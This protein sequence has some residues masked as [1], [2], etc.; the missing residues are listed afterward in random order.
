M[1]NQHP[2]PS[3]DRVRAMN[4]EIGNMRRAFAADFAAGKVPVKDRFGRP[5]TEGS[6]I[7]WHPP[8]DLVYQVEK[9]EPILDPNQPP[10]Y[11]RVTVT[12]QAPVT[13]PAGQSAPDIIAVGNAKD[14]HVVVDG[15]FPT[16]APPEPEDQQPPA[17]TAGESP[18]AAVDVPGA[19]APAPI[20]EPP[21]TGGG[22]GNVSGT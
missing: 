10:G 15:M 1:S 19:D 2:R 7:V 21:P 6:L 18:N 12:L 5:V 8:Q 20:E 14:G 3:D 11:V 16:A 13:W 17:P 22:D 9:V 4:R